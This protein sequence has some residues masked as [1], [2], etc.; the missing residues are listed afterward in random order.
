[1]FDTEYDPTENSNSPFH[2]GSD[3]L[4]VSFLFE[5]LIFSM[6]SKY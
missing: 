1:M 4:N 5:F 6:Y 2:V 3:I